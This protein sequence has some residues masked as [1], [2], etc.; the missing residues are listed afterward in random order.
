MYI[1]AFKGGRLRLDKKINNDSTDLSRIIEEKLSEK[2]KKAAELIRGSRDYVE[3]GDIRN[4]LRKVI[5]LWQTLLEALII[6]YVAEDRTKQLGRIGIQSSDEIK[7]I[8]NIVENVEQVVKENMEK[9]V[10]YLLRYINDD[11]LPTYT[12]MVLML[13]EGLES[14]RIEGME[15][16]VYRI[17][18]VAE[19]MLKDY[20]LDFVPQGID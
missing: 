19:D 13:K 15:V 5:E 1:S 2:I 4:A 16:K 11:R 20:F 3:K 14:G 7:N 10:R 9:S 18:Q 17:T 8:T 12:Y 6:R